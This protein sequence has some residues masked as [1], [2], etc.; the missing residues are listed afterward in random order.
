MQT[1]AG[2]VNVLQTAILSEKC[3][4]F[5]PWIS[6]GLN[7]SKMMGLARSQ[8]KKAHISQGIP[9]KGHRHRAIPLAGE[10]AGR[11]H[12]KAGA[13]QEGPEGHLSARCCPMVTL[14][15]FRLAAHRTTTDTKRS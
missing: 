14:P 7:P 3:L 5:N 6:T 11:D 15:S 2:L 4:L 9:A 13:D 8:P 10:A 1:E 12:I